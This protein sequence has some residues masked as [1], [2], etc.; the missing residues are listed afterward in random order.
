LDRTRVRREALASEWAPRTDPALELPPGDA[1]LAELADE[2]VVPTQPPSLGL[3]QVLNDAVFGA[4][5]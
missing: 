3:C 4:R 1:T 5:P 2:V